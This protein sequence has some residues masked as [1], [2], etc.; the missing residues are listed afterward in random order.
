MNLADILV[1]LAVLGI[2]ALAVGILRRN[3]KN[4]KGSCGCGCGCS[5]C[6]DSCKKK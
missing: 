3:K 5:G 1:I 4:G 6:S 2:V